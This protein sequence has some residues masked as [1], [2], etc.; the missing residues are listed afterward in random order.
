MP[1]LTTFTA[2]E[3]FLSSCTCDTLHALQYTLIS[4]YP[5]H[6]TNTLLFLF[7]NKHFRHFHSQRSLSASMAVCPAAVIDQPSVT[8]PRSQFCPAR[9]TTFLFHIPFCCF[10]TV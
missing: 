10:C 5:S 7:T 8:A 9:H 2:I 3:P 1:F 4:R 6:D